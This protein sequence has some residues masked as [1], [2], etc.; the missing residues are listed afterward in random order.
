MALVLIADDDPLILRLL[1]VSLAGVG[2][3]VVL[4]TDGREALD[5]VRQEK[6]DI[7]LLDGMMPELSGL[8]VLQA[9]K[10]DKATKDLPVVLMTALSE[11]DD[12]AKG[13]EL[14]AN[15]YLV[16]PFSPKDMIAVIDRLIT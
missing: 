3:S 8:E 15:E 5:L 4:A 6:P 13:L 2:H 11:R 14:G 9:L 10:D 16:K 7:L 12:I 1:E